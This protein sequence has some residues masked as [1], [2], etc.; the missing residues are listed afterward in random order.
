MN[1][2]GSIPTVNSF[3]AG[4]WS[5]AGDAMSGVCRRDNRPIIR[6]VHRSPRVRP[7]GLIDVPLSIQ[8]NRQKAQ[9]KQTVSHLSSHLLFIKSPRGERERE[10]ERE[11]ER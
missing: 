2:G 10:R 5:Y 3:T 6:A 1:Q 7:P 11:G 8:Q 4:V 9:P